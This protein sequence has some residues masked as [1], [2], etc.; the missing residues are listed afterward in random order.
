MELL[1]MNMS[2]RGRPVGFKMTQKSKDMIGDSS[3]GKTPVNCRK[4]SIKGIVYSSITAAS[5]AI[6][7]NH[8][9]ICFRLNSKSDRFKDWIY[10]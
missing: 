4:V 6:D 1:G 2:K 10:L 7:I 5:K 9:T 3:R 8:T